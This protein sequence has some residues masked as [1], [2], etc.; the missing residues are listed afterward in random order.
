M[1]KILLILIIILSIK[2]SYSQTYEDSRNYF[3]NS[4]KKL[5]EVYNQLI[6]GNKSDASFIKN[7]RTSERTWIQYRDAQLTLLYPGYSLIGKSDSLSRNELIYLSYLT[8]NRTKILLEMLKPLTIK[9]VYVS[10]L[11]VIYAGNIH[12]G[13]GIDKPYWTSELVIC[14][15][16]YDKGIV[17][18]PEAGGPVAYVEF[19]IPKAGGQLL[20]V[21]GWADG[22]GNNSYHG[23]MRYRIILDGRLVYG[24]ELV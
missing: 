23:R 1:K 9:K 3:E 8:E 10:D 20:G 7:L 14:G 15:K 22:T 19:Q 18:H 6:E 24:N 21:V 16:K 17:V 2:L 12:G 5:N 4:D 11:E 13:L